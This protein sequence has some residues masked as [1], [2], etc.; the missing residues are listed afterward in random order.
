MGHLMSCFERLRRPS[1]EYL[2]LFPIKEYVDGALDSYG[3]FKDEKAV[4][5]ELTNIIDARYRSQGY[6][7]NWLLFSEHEN[8][9]S[10]DLNLVS[11]YLNVA[12]DCI[13]TAGVSFMDHVNNHT[14]ADVD[15]V[16]DQL[17]AHCKL[18]IG[19][20][21]Q[22]D[23]VDRIAK[24]SYER[25]INTFVDEDTT[26]MFFVRMVLDEIP[27][28]RN[29]W[30]LPALGIPEDDWAYDRVVKMRANKPWFVQK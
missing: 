1:K 9:D 8:P 2:F 4:V 18:V 23:C 25:G 22:Y 21:H 14:Y 6:G 19:G 16:L 12:G 13:L 28:V 15:Y 3:R 11:E 24:R 30:T 17:P 27:L 26:E 7:I 10:P 20:F 29:E 5:S